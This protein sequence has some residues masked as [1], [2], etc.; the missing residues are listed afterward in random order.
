MDFIFMKALKPSG[1]FAMSEGFRMKP[2]AC[3][4]LKG[5]FPLANTN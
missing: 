1:A 4:A 5:T 3:F 2:M